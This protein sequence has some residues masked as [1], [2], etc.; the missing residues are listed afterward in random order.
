MKDDEYEMEDDD[1][2]YIDFSIDKDIK[3]FARL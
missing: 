3:P 1:E 2:D